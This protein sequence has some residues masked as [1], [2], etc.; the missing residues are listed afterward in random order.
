MTFIKTLLSLFI[1]C[2][3]T[4][5]LLCLR[6]YI[7]IYIYIYIYSAIFQNKF[8]FSNKNLYRTVFLLLSIRGKN[9][10][11]I[12]DSFVLGIIMIRS[13]IKKRACL[14]ICSLNVYFKT[15]KSL[16]QDFCDKKAPTYYRK[17]NNKK[18]NAHGKGRK[19]GLEKHRVITNV[20][21]W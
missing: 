11:L 1:C 9:R 10:F 6:P 4:E 13:C 15:Q 3:I 14:S 8:Y 5:S 12:G 16:N 19:R 21:C 20:P 18:Q 7:Y 17:N 2:P